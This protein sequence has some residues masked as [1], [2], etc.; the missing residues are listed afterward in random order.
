MQA[1]LNLVWEHLLPAMM[2]A[3][4]PQDDA[5]HHALR[6]ALQALE[7]PAAAGP[8][9]VAS[10]GKANGKVNGKTYLVAPN[11]QQIASLR[12]AIEGD[13]VTIHYND[14]SGDHTL[15]IGVGRWVEGELRLMAGEDVRYRKPLRYAGSGGWQSET[16]FSASLVCIE[17]PFIPHLTCTFEGDDVKLDLVFDRFMGPPPEVHLSGKR[18]PVPA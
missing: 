3:P 1:V 12:F 18:E 8:G 7:I 11:P 13:S 10:S 5:A 6:S 17:T 16:T 4:L 9:S 14:A 15:P 2:P